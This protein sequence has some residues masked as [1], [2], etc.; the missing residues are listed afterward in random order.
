[1]DFNLVLSP[2][3]LTISSEM[4]P[5]KTRFFFILEVTVDGNPDKEILMR[6]INLASGVHENLFLQTNGKIFK[7][8]YYAGRFRH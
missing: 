1:M 5:Y 4:I 2:S 8:L 6:Q 3:P 7:G